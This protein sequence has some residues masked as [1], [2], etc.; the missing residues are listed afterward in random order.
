MKNEELAALW[1]LV[2]TREI[3]NNSLQETWST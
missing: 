1:L 2:T 3:M